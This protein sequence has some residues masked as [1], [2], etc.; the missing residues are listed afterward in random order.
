MNC[1]NP[2][3]SH[4]CT[5]GKHSKNTK[6]YHYSPTT[7]TKVISKLN[8]VNE[9]CWLEVLGENDWQFQYNNDSPIMLN[10]DMIIQIPEGT[11]Y[12]LIKGSTPLSISIKS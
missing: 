6:V 3:V 1:K 8:T 2:E 11:S 10:S 7:P 9:D 5:C 4:T 12:R